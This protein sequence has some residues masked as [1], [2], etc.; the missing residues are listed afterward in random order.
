MV[1]LLNVRGKVDYFLP[2]EV[3]YH[4]TLRSPRYRPITLPYISNVRRRNDI[5]IKHAEQPQMNQKGV[6]TLYIY[7]HICM[8]PTFNFRQI[9]SGIGEFSV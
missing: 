8:Y 7:V 4:D 3:Y 1:L 6:C 9:S 5:R 2:V